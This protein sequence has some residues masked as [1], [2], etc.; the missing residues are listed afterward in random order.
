MTKIKLLLIC[1]VVLALVIPNLAANQ[2]RNKNNRSNNRSNAPK[3]KLQADAPLPGKL[4][5]LN[6]FSAIIKFQT[7]FIQTVDWDSTKRRNFNCITTFSD[8]SSQ[9]SEVDKSIQQKYVTFG[10]SFIRNTFKAITSQLFTD[11]SRLSF[12]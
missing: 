3:K 2:S 9:K 11:H 10:L 8:L 12:H 1:V 4:K 6:H 5:G 7:L